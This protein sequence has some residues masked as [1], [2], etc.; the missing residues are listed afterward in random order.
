MNVLPNILGDGIVDQ[1]LQAMAVMLFL[2]VFLSVL[3]NFGILYLTWLEMSTTLQPHTTNVTDTYSQEP[4]IDTSKTCFPSRNEV[5][6]TEFTYSIFLN[7]T[8]NSFSNDPNRLRHIF[9]KGS[10]PPDGYPLIAPGV[11]CHADQNTLRVMMG[12]S[13]RWDN[14]VDIPNIP[15]GKWFHLV[16]TCKGRS[17][18]VYINGN[19]IQRLTL[20]SVPKLNFGDVYLLQNFSNSDTRVNIA[21]DQQFNV[22]GAANCSI[23]RFLYFAYS[24]SYAEIDQLYRQGP[25]TTVVSASNQI[26]PYMA[27]AWWVQSY[28]Q[29]K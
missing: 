15:V 25:S 3:N 13:D 17:I 27:D 9:H 22:I 2:Y 21:P 20:G 1:V 12:S 18:D 4:N 6:G 5:N 10:P 16:I 28:N 11:F 19:V 14:F 23:S 8:A 26:P 29:G 7:F 24:L